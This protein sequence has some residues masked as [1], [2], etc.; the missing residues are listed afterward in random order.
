MKKIVVPDFEAGERLDAWLVQQDSKRSRSAFQKHIKE[1]GILVNGKKP[2][3]H[4]I[5][6]EGDVVEIEKAASKASLKAV[7]PDVPDVAIVDETDEYLVINKPSGLLVHPAP[8]QKTS[9]LVDFLLAHAPKIKGV[10]DAKER[11]GIVHRLDREASGLMVVAKTK[12]AYA[13]LKKQFQAH[14]IK[15]EYLA[16]VYGKPSKDFDLIDTPIGRKKGKGRMSAR[17]EAQEGDKD[18]RTHFDVLE[19]FPQAAFI[20]VRTETGRMHQV[21]VHMKSI[22]HPLVGDDLYAGTKHETPSLRNTRLF[23]HAA[24]LGFTDL[25]GAWREYHSELPPELESVV[26]TL[27]KKHA[28]A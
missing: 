12:K 11:P 28:K 23:L 17:A 10:G 22:G 18:A 3:A 26:E 19:R 6:K 21:R 9:T 24:T 1:G 7:K 5:L 15:K 13:H 2:K 4:Y 25:S 20:K 16:L 14:E 27:R 8:S